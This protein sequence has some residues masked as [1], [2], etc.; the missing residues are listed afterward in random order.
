MLSLLSAPVAILFELYLFCDEFLVFA[1][2]IIHP[3]A[4]GAGKF[5]KSIL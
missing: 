5:Y 3:F 4:D 1:G 2:P